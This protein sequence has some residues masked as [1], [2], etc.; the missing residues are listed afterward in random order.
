[1]SQDGRYQHVVFRHVVAGKSTFHLYLLRATALWNGQYKSFIR[2]R[3][4]DKN[5]TK[6][7]NSALNI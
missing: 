7:L 3:K 5:V 4:G 2:A 1:M 6:M